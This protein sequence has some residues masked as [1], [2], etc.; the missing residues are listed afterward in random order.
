MSDCPNCGKLYTLGDEACQ[1]CGYVFPFSTDIVASGT[2]LQGRY[3]TEELAHSGGM[4]YIYLARNTK[5]H[6]RLCIVKQVKDP[7][8]SDDDLKKLEQE[9]I[10][11]AKLSHP[12]VA[13]IFDHFV[14]GRFYFLVVEYIAG[15]TLSEIF[16]ERQGH[17]AEE[18]VINWAISMCD[19]VS[20]LHKQGIVHRD[21]SPQNIMITDEGIIKF[22]DFGTLR[23]LRHIATRGTA[24]MGKFG[25]APP[26][27]WLG[28]PEPCSD[29]FALGATIYYLLTGF[30]P[31]SKE[32]LAG[33]G[34]QRAD[35]NPDFPPI[36]QKNERVSPELEAVLQKALQ[37]DA[38]SRYSSATELRQALMNLIEVKAPV[39][40]VDCDQLDFT[41]TVA[42][43]Q[44]AKNFTL[45]NVGINRLT[46]KLTTTKS[47]LKVSPATLDLE[48]GEQEVSVTVDATSLAT[49]FSDIGNIDIVT[50]G[51]EA[52]IDVTLSTTSFAKRALGVGLTWAGRM[53]WLILLVMVI[54]VAAAIVPKTILKEPVLGIDSTQQ[55]DFS[56]I[57]VGDISSSR[58]LIITNTGGSLLTG[59]AKSTK[60]WLIVSPTEIKLPYGEEKITAQLDTRNLPYGFKDTGFIDIETNGGS[61]QIAVNLTI[62]NVIYED[63]FSDSSSGW[64]VG[65]SDTGEARYGNGGYR[66]LTKR[67]SS[68]IAGTNPAIGQ[69]SDFVLE[70]DAKSLSSARDSSYGVILKQQD[71]S[72]FDNLYYFHISS[73]SGQYK[74]ERLSNGKWS[75]LTEW[76]DSTHISKAPSVN[77]LKVICR[78]KQIE[79]YVNDIS[80]ATI[81]DDSFPNGFIGLAAASGFEAESKADVVFDNITI[82][83]PD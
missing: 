58:T 62:T 82:Y 22:I 27:Q 31:L 49:G 10:E 50:N 53:K 14:E 35:F 8:K 13:M 3:K 68:I 26:E 75:T 38:N 32:Y 18:E 66:L 57:K 73:S 81:T 2:I 83:I 48:A 17:L 44:S 70:V 76:T 59:T 43:R 33:Q 23:E 30:L 41:Q 25:Y 74:V 6:D 64:T 55:I 71:T 63:D 20:Y 39:L 79:L 78:G 24:G 16:Q 52:S 29:I 47:W 60:D 37:L 11:M 67:T 46:G 9:A 51:G 1:Y 34:P 7:V 56:D 54:A 80:L 28:K 40:S 15:K 69:L 72:R 12:N 45:M 21:I 5:L 42:G 19:V 61:L 65:S 77:Q 4:G 36:R